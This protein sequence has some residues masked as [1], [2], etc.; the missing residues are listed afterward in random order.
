MPVQ[1]KALILT[2][3]DQPFQLVDFII[4]D[5]SAGEL[6]INI[7]S[8]GVCH[9]D[10]SVQNGTIPGLPFPNILGHEGAGIMEQVGEGVTGFEVGDK[11]LLSFN[12]CGSCRSVMMGFLELVR[13]GLNF[14][15]SKPRSGTVG[16]FGEDKEQLRVCLFRFWV[17]RGYTDSLISHTGRIFWSIKLC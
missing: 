17:A 3:V 15:T 10:I 11:V 16:S 2:G 12:H 13:V 9:T 5:A 6:L 8:T 7:H 1:S 14:G 4:D